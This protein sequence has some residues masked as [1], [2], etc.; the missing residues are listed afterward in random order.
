M[1]RATREAA[2]CRH[3][4]CHN[5]LGSAQAAGYTRRNNLLSLSELERGVLWGGC[6]RA[7]FEGRAR[8]RHTAMHTRS[9]HS[10]PA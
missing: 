5:G 10:T 1:R 3:G 4:S 6:V 9:S 8:I 7:A 2:V